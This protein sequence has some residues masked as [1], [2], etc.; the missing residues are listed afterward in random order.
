M[1]DEI[2][3]IEADETLAGRGVSRREFAALGGAAVAALG[4]STAAAAQAAG[5]LAEATVSIPTPDGAMDAFFVHPAEGAHPAVIMWPDIAGVR[6]AFKA[7]ARALAAKGYAVACVN[8]YYRS[9]KAPVMAS[10]SEFFDPAGRAKLQPMIQKITNPGIMSDAKAIV[11]W[12]DK[13]PAVDATKKVGV[14][15]YC[16]TGGY[17]ARC[18]AAVPARIGAACSFH[19]AGIVTDAP[20]SPH[21]LIKDSDPECYFLFAIARNDNQRSPDDKIVLGKVAEETGRGIRA[22][23]FQADHGWC[24]PDT[25]AYNNQEAE[26]AR[27]LGLWFYSHANPAP[28]PARGGRR[29]G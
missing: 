19:G 23:V 2:T 18:A 15:G 29:P 27:Q 22:E 21:K 26:R 12:L 3:V 8:Q 7:M 14:E 25:P 9:S 4:L 1:C 11:A 28:A 24:V 13:Q 5:G 16:M 6:D 10:I 17:G 20:D